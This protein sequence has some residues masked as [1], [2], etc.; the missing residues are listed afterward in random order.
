MGCQAGIKFSPTCFPMP[1]ATE[2]DACG[3]TQI[4]LLVRLAA[5]VSNRS[6][7]LLRPARILPFFMRGGA[8]QAHDSLVAN[9][10]PGHPP[11]PLGSIHRAPTH[12]V[13]WKETPLGKLQALPEGGK[14]VTTWS[15]RDEAFLH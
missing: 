3:G 15:N 12:P 14:A 11:S 13:S 4:T 6:L 5:R 10:M 9:A 1:G 7:T 2:G 8:P